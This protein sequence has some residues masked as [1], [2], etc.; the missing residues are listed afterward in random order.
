MLTYAYTCVVHAASTPATHGD[1][2]IG[3]GFILDHPGI[4]VVFIESFG[5]MN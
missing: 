1:V 4:S 3:E 5:G 2:A